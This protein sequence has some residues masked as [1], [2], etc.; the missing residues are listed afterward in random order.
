MT[1]LVET[2]T[3]KKVALDLSKG[4][5]IDKAFGKNLTNEDKENLKAFV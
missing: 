3:L 1:D 5:P 2:D 4:V